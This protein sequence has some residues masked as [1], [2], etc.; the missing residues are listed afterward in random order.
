MSVVAIILARKNSK[1]LKNKNIKLL[2]G[3]P[4]IYHS[5]DILKKRRLINDIIVSSDSKKIRDMAIKR[6][7]KA[8][9]LR[10][11]SLSTDNATSD[12]AL[13]H[14]LK[15]LN[16]KKL[17]PTIVV[18]LQIT[19]PLRKLW[20]IEKCIKVLKNRMDQFNVSHDDLWWYKDLRR[21]G[22]VPHSGFGLGFERIVLFATGMNNIRDVIP[23]PRT[24]N[25]ALF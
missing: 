25:N 3:K 11:K 12:K 7:V 15:F 20:M 1:G 4:L 23:F 6:G 21:F 16:K 2:N 19:E 8:P 13:R 18:Y 14:C 10:P 24:P 5:I 22:T 17:Y 9:F